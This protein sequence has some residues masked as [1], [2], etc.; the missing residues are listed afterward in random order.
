MICMLIGEAHNETI[1][2]FLKLA[3]AAFYGALAWEASREER[4]AEAT[5]CNG[6][7]AVY[8][9]SVLM[10]WMPIVIHQIP[11]FLDVPIEIAWQNLLA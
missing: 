6:L 1:E 8:L 2:K 9:T 10:E 3:F 4:W 5:I 11:I 7:M